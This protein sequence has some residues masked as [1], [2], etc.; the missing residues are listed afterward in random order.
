MLSRDGGKTW[1]DITRGLPT[2]FITSIAVDT[3]NSE[4]AYLTVSGFGSGHVFKT[5]D[6]GASWADIS[7]SLPDIPAN[8]LLIDPARPNILYLG[9]DVG[10]FRSISAGESWHAFSDGMPPVIVTALASHPSGVIQAATYG[11]GA[12]ELRISV[13]RPVISSVVY[14]GK[15]KLT[16]RGSLF[17]ATP[18]VTVNDIDLTGRVK[19]SSDT[20]INIKAKASL[21]GLRP[22]DNSVQV[23]GSDGSTSNTFILTL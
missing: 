19:N 16:I 4:I 1:S 12:Y 14:N 18:R 23:I 22:G 9:T 5:E 3:S 11:R 15:K 17:G 2:R 8:D 21:L 10:V 20:T 6:G 13:E 7:R